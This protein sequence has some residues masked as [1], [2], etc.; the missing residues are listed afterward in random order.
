MQEFRGDLKKMLGISFA[1]LT[2]SSSQGVRL[3]VVGVMDSFFIS[4]SLLS[5]SSSFKPQF[6]ASPLHLNNLF[7]P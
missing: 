7:E 2:S 3:S 4:F 1:G 6:L 5:I